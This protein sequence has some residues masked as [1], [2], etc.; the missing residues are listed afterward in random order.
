[1]GMFDKDKLFAPDGQLNSDDGSG[2]AQPG[3]EF[4][5]WDCHIQTETF[6]FD[7]NEDAIPMAHLVVSK[8]TDPESKKTV[9]TLSKPICEKVREKEDGDLPAI[10]RLQTVPASQKSWND[11]VVLQFISE[12][13]PKAKAS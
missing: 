7:P 10:V 1:M 13:K 3:D 2:F 12:Y 5:L 4:V 9:S 6:E 8:T 11:A